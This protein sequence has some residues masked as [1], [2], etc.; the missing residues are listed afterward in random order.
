MKTRSFS[1]VAAFAA[2]LTISNHAEAVTLISESF[3]APTHTAG[4]APVGW[5][6]TTGVVVSGVARTGTQSLAS[7]TVS[8][9][10]QLSRAKL[11]GAQ[12][13]PITKLSTFARTNNGGTTF[14]STQFAFGGENRF[15]L[16]G[17]FTSTNQWFVQVLN[18]GGS[19]LYSTSGA[20]S[21]YNTTQWN[22]YEVI[23]DRAAG[24]ASFRL[25]GNQVSNLNNMATYFT[26]DAIAIALA[27]NSIG[28]SNTRLYF[29]D[30][31]VESVPEPGTM[32]ALSLGLAAILRRR[33]S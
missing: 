32:A 14:L 5:S 8:G 23:H 31:K 3:E 15:L 33:R 29:D 4:L 16:F 20:L 9:S 2:T 25:N 10:E 13:A 28:S 22:Q 7:T 24:A 27:G 6:G 1:I 18:S 12:T 21:G 17:T 26:S 19:T 11:I 30:A